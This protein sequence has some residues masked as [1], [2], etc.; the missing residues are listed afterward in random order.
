MELKDILRFIQ[1]YFWL[2]LA[3]LVIG[4]IAGFVLMWIRPAEYQGVTKVLISRSNPDKSSTYGYLTDDQ[5]VQTFQYLVKTEAILSEASD[6][7]GF[8]IDPEKVQVENIPN[9]M[10]LQVSYFSQN[11]QVAADTANA[12]VS[13]LIKQNQALQAR[14]YAQQ[15]ES[16]NQQIE[17]VKQQIDDLQQQYDA[18]VEEVNTSQINQVDQQ[19][20]D[21]SERIS[22]LKKEIAALGT[23][24]DP[25]SRSKLAEMQA[26]VDEYQPLLTL[27]QQIRTN[28]EYLG[29]PYQSGS[30]ADDQVL[31]RLNTLIGQF[32]N[33]YFTLINKLEDT[34]LESRKNTS[35]LLQIET[36]IAPETQSTT[37]LLTNPVIMGLVFLILA[38]FVALILQMMDTTIHTSE[39]TRNKLGIETLETITQSS[40]TIDFLNPKTWSFQNDNELGNNYLA[41][42]ASLE[43]IR[44]THPFKT[45][46]I[47]SFIPQE[48]KSTIAVNLAINYASGGHK[49]VLVDANFDNS[50]SGKK[51]FF[52]KAPGL[53]DIL[54]AGKDF[55]SELLKNTGVRG[56]RVLPLG[57]TIPDPMK[58]AEANRMRSLTSSII[59]GRDIVIFDGAD[60]GEENTRILSTFVDA[61]LIVLRPGSMKIE[62]AVEI[63]QNLHVKPEKIVG[64][65]LNNYR[66][67]R[68]VKKFNLSAIQKIF[69]KE[70]QIVVVEAE[71]KRITGW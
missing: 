2:L 1:K 24:L 18:R 17:Q 55:G 28:L 21:Y 15:E 13:A 12:L 38:Y 9:S 45:L 44:K 70:K 33:I 66:Q 25:V 57:E 22:T 34:E 61:I 51:T 68:K 35:M 32:Q 48:G 4:V 7:V 42:R 5:L 8:K 60:L 10:I 71:Q 69:K 56:V 65:V 59:R 39:Q 53:T 27:Y 50:A 46:L 64:M 40:T 26:Q 36:A 54:F 3:G 67:N 16:L 30:G 19:I 62:E 41:L 37:A 47:S 49:V 11:P 29:R 43:L 23:P 20:A 58:L 63:L 6:T 52:E 31:I 14:N